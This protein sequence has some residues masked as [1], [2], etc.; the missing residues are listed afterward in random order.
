[1]VM[2]MESGDLLEVTSSTITYQNLNIVGSN[3]LNGSYAALIKS[4]ANS[5]GGFALE[6]CIIENCDDTDYDLDEL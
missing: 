3:T 6:D 1:M 4:Q 2:H 5:G